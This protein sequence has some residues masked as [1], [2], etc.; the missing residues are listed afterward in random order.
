MQ[1]KSFNLAKTESKKK[2]AAF[3]LSFQKNSTD[4]T[5]SESDLDSNVKGF[6]MLSLRR[7]NLRDYMQ[8]KEVEIP[9]LNTKLL[10]DDTFAYDT[11]SA[12]GISTYR[13]DFWQLDQSDVAKD[14]AIIKGPS[15]GTPKCGGRWI[16]IFTFE[17]KGVMMGLFHPPGIYAVTDND[18]LEFRLA[19]AMVLQRHGIRQI[20]GAF[21]E[22]NIIECDRTKAKFTARIEHKL[23]LP[24]RRQGDMTEIEE[25]T[26]YGNGQLQIEGLHLDQVVQ[27]DVEQ[28][29]SIIAK[30]TMRGTSRKVYI[31]KAIR[32]LRHQKEE[33][34]LAQGKSSRSKR[35]KNENPRRLATKIRRRRGSLTYLV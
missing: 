6:C 22:L 32:Q 8:R 31:L 18:D 14:S 20:G 13:D 34:D 19:P 24:G 28:L 11:G 35:R 2:E 9:F 27:S 1:K 21:K 4:Y 23:E 12:E 33:G 10:Q 30:T 26:M 16:V 29:A 25:S 15:V 5:E 3:R 7:T 17:E